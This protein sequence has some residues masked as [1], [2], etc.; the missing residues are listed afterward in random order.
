MTLVGHGMFGVRSALRTFQDLPSQARKDAFIEIEGGQLISGSWS[1]SGGAY[2]ISWA[3]TFDDVA[4]H[5]TTC[6]TLAETLT[7][8]ESVADCQGTEGTYYHKQGLGTLYVHLT[9]GTDPNTLDVRVTTTFGFCSG[10]VESEHFVQ[11]ILGNEL[12][13][14]SEC[15]IWSSSTNLTNY[16]EDLSGAGWTVNQESTNVFSGTYSCKLD[17]TGAASGSAQIRQNPNVTVGEWYRACGYYYTPTTARD[18]QHVYVRYGTSVSLNADGRNPDATLSTG[19]EL[20]ATN[21]NWRFF[22]YDFVAHE[23]DARLAFRLVNG[24]AAASTVYFDKLS[25]RRI[26]GWRWYVPR[27]AEGGVPQ[28]QFGATDLYPGS[29]EIGAGTVRLVNDSDATMERLFSPPWFF[30]SQS[31]RV[32]HGGAFS[33][34]SPSFGIA[35]QEILYNDMEPGFHGQISGSSDVEVSDLEAVIQVEDSRGI[36]QAQL[37]TR[38]YNGS[39]FPDGESRDTGRPRPLVFGIKLNSRPSRIDIEATKGYGIYEAC[40]TTD[41]SVGMGGVGS[42]AGGFVYAYADEEAADKQDAA[43]RV[44]LSDPL[45]DYDQDLTAG[46]FEITADVRVIEITRE[47]N[48][49]DFHVGGANLVATIADGPYCIGY[50]GGTANDRGLCLA[51]TNAMTAAAGLTI[52]ATYSE[53]THLVTIARTTKGTLSLL[54]NTGANDATSL[55]PTLGFDGGADDTGLTSYAGDSVL[56]EDPDSTHIIRADVNGLC[57]DG[58]GTYT[59]TPGNA[60]QRAPDI[61]HFILREILKLPASRIDTASFLAAQSTCAQACGVYL[62]GLASVT[63]GAG[64]DMTVQEVIDRFEAG[65]FADVVMDGRGV[66]HFNK[67][68]S[69]VPATAPHVFDKDFHAFKGYYSGNSAYGSIRVNYDQDPSTGVV[70]GSELTNNET[71]LLYNRPQLRTFDTF[72]TVESDA[73]DARDLLG[74]LARAPIRHFD[75][76]V[77]SAKMLRLK[78][79]DVFKITRSQALQ[80]VGESGGL[81][82]DVFRVMWIRKDFVNHIVQVICHTNVVS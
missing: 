57:D 12:L 20:T 63:G 24:S 29:E 62:G 17:A 73:D 46:T 31:V 48:K 1:A 70:K 67:R 28:V 76:T 40:D 45:G 6:R 19:A 64:F 35:G 21:G 72:L 61:L 7:L 41:W 59:G 26:F 71:V 39:Q 36:L 68:T 4:L 77:S 38:C 43:R 42:A 3:E 74:V 56:F 2:S 55:G 10:G 15:D 25:C 75:L 58:S 13:S 34:D 33:S 30:S 60:L 8:T 32:L 23:A 81:D 27:I 53:T 5:V 18:T 66:F 65:A 54:W 50:G 69:T 37:P 82:A 47:N 9:G 22:V 49:I 79:G 14:D 80:G 78:V 51:I 44:E 52:Q 16:T 11:P